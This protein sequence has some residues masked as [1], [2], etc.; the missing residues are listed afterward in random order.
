[1]K[2]CVD[3]DLA[4]LQYSPYIFR[5][6]NNYFLNISKVRGQIRPAPYGTGLI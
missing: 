4:P 2:D 5:F 1:M 3:P 6:R